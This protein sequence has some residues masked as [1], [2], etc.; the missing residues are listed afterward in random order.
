MLI[1][2]QLYC[3]GV[4]QGVKAK[5]TEVVG[6]GDFVE[7]QLVPSTAITNTIAMLWTI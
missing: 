1:A 6:L 7:Q 2:L 4:A 3:G 5:A